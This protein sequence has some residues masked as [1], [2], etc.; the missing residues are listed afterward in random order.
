MD[1]EYCG[2]IY[3]FSAASAADEAAQAQPAEAAS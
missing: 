3:T 1:N 2:L